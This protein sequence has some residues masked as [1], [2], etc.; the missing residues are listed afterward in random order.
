[1]IAR[2]YIEARGI[3][4]RVVLIDDFFDGLKLVY[5]GEAD[6]LFQVA[7]HPD[8]A[9]VVAEA[10]F[11]YGI[12]IIDTFISPSKDL[13]VIT[14]RDVA[15][16]RTLALQPATKG[17]ADLSPWEE[18]IPVS[19][20]MHIAD[21]LLEGRYDSGLTTIEFAEKHPDKLRV[22][23]HIGSVDD[24]WLVFGKQRVAQGEP[25]IWPDSP[26][27]EQFKKATKA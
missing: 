11:K 25:L 7:V 14:R 15:K 17:Y 26:V 13:G 21:G 10:H 16:P 8:C 2:K 6:F 27:I 20:I 5:E 9:D 1:M 12:H 18:H 4:A 3:E 22:D 24:P 23:I 19:S